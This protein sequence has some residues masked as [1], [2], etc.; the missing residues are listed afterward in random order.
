MR[1]P[2][3]HATLTSRNRAIDK[4]KKEYKSDDAYGFRIRLFADDKARS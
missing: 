1:E 4:A 2:Q 3:V